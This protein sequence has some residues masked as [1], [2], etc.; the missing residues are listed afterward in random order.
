MSKT[1]RLIY[2]AL[3]ISMAIA[4]QVFESMIA[5]PLP[6]G[7]KLGLANIIALVTMEIFDVRELILVNSMR[8]LLGSLLRGTFLTSTFWISTGGVLLS[9]LAIIFMKKF[10]KQ[11]MI[12]ISIVSAVF[13]NIGQIIV[14]TFLYNNVALAAILPILLITAIPTGILVGISAKETSSRVKF[15]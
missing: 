4:L 13:H 6:Y 14:I 1:K 15:T 11:S 3:L 7:A 8:V 2:L 9:S 10:T 5:I 12:G